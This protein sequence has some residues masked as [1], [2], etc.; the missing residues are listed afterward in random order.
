MAD[1]KFRTTF[2]DAGDFNAC[3]AAERWCEA[4]GIAVGWMQGPDPRGLLMGDYTISKWRNLNARERRGL[5]GTMTGD[6]RSGP[7]TVTLNGAEVDYPLLASE[8]NA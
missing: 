2:D 8:S 6:M 5:D 3:N 7:V 4:R 1:P